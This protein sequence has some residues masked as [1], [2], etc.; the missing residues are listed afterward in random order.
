MQRANMLAQMLTDR[1][2]L[3][4]LLRDLVSS[5]DLTHELFP[6]PL[7]PKDLAMRWHTSEKKLESD[8]LTGSGIPYFRLPG[9]RLVRY[10]FHFILGAEQNVFR[11][12]SEEDCGSP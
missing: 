1:Q 3:I 11:S 7:S 4:E 10:P 6:R 12:T 2:T 9:S 5:G 8:R